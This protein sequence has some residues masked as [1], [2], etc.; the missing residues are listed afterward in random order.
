PS[1]DGG[2]TGFGNNSASTS[3]YGYLEING[4]YIYYINPLTVSGAT[5]TDSLYGTIDSS[6]YAFTLS[7]GCSVNNSG[8]SYT[9][10]A[11]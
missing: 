6:T 9:M 11:N 1:G 5:A 8:T 3:S 10:T 7:S 2:S 4:G